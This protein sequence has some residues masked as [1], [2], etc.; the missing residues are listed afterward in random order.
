MDDSRVLNALTAIPDKY[1]IFSEEDQEKVTTLYG[2]IKE[3]VI[4]RDYKH[5]SRAAAKATV[6][7]LQNC[8][9]YSQISTRTLLRWYEL[10]DVT[11]KK[12]G[13]KENEIFESEVWGNLMLCIFSK[14]SDQVR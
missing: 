2:I 14:R 5:A 4:E 6:K 13:R 7:I 1:V 8:R 3:V 10:K 12:T 11:N 9:Y